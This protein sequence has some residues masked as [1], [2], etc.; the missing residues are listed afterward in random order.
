VAAGTAHDALRQLA[1]PAGS[2]LLVNGAGGG[3]GTAVLQLARLAG[4]TVIGVASAAKQDLVRRFG[5]IPVAYGD[6][7][8]DRVRAAAP[9]GIDAAFDL[10]GGAALRTIAEVVPDRRRLLSVAD[11]TLVLE[12]GGA[13]VDRDRSTAVLAELAGLVADGAFDPH[14]TEVRPLAE[15]GA[16][17]RQVESGHGEGKVVVQVA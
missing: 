4:L 6:G 14:V 8:L 5:A 17:M 2:T 15:A 3:V 10:A 1:L 11:R 13:A 9:D 7:V 12:L 16:A